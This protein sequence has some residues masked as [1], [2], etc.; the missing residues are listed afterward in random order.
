MRKPWY[1][2]VLVLGSL[3]A[4]CQAAPAGS[5]MAANSPAPLSSPATPNPPAASS[6]AAGPSPA[7]HPRRSSGAAT[8]KPTPTAS[9]SPKPSVSSPP[10]GTVAFDPF[11]VITCTWVPRMFVDLSGKAKPGIAVRVPLVATQVDGAITATIRSELNGSLSKDTQTV[12]VRQDWR[13]SVTMRLAA[14]A[15]GNF[16]SIVSE[17]D[18]SR[19]T[20]EGA[21]PDPR[22]SSDQEFGCS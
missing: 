5:P 11:A 3:T 15:Y 20:V 14:P 7:A 18:G 17:L 2:V 22:P 21:I 1:A 19:R 9:K 16:V 10:H 13:G 6:P 8:T 12:E 4:G